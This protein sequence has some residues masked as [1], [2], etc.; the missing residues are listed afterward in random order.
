MLFMDIW[1]WEPERR[2]EM[3]KRWAEWKYPEGIKVIGEWLD[4]TG[5]RFFLLYVVEDPKVLLEANY[6]WT[7]LA[8]VESVP[9]M[10]FGEVSKL[11]PK[12]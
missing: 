5:N 2:N 3:E 12:G 11:L 7:D 1:T 10:E 4:L 6:Y 8:K 9:V